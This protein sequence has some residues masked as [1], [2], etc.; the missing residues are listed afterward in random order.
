M[1]YERQSQHIGRQKTIVAI[2]RKLL[3]TVWHVL[4]RQEADRFAD[5]QQV[6]T[7]LFAFAHKVRVQNLSDG[8][9]ALQFTRNQLDRLKIGQSVQVIP[10][11]VKRY[12]LPPSRLPA[13]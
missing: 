7:A 3:V 11:G 10:W 12:K 13:S 6:A 1:V 9:C 8:Q 5:H 4:S 2:A